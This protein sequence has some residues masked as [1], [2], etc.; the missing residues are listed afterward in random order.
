MRDPVDRAHSAGHSHTC[1]TANCHVGNDL[2]VLD[3]VLDLSSE[4]EGL[5]F[6]YQG[7]VGAGREV[8]LVSR[9]VGSR[10]QYF[11]G[12]VRRDR[13]PTA[14]ISNECSRR[15]RR[16]AEMAALIRIKEAATA[17]SRDDRR[18]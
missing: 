13:K 16:L 7:S 2:A 11:D 4:G 14:A 6:A 15:S 12:Y 3:T 18:R 17:T 10:A 1:R 5:G 9:I 8:T